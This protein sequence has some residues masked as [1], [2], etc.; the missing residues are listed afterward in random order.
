M[1]ESFKQGFIDEL[2]KLGGD[3]VTLPN[4]WSDQNSVTR[5]GSNALKRV[6]EKLQLTKRK[7]KGFNQN[8]VAENMLP[9]SGEHIA[10]RG[11]M[12]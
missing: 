10:L 11:D 3:P 6:R 2:T 5:T 12:E 4:K 7:G 8:A 9:G 1:F